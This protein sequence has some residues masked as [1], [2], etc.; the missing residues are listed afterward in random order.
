MTVLEVTVRLGHW[1]GVTYLHRPVDQSF[2]LLL[3]K[4]S[5]MYYEVLTDPKLVGASTSATAA[6][7]TQ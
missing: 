3:Q 7:E 2:F 5:Q 1:T 4:L 6:P